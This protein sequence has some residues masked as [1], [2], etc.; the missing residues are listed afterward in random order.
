MS[1]IT[2]EGAELGHLLPG[3]RSFGVLQ[4]ARVLRVGGLSAKT[5]LKPDDVIV[6]VDMTTIRTP[7]D[8]FD[9][10]ATKTGAYRL[11]I[12]RAGKLCWLRVKEY[13]AMAP[14]R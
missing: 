2:L 8:V 4:G 9:A 11:E 13:E 6:K 14:D 7:Q 3:F 5:G 10:V 1:A 12:D